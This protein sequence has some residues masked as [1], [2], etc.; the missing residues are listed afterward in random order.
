MKKFKKILANKSIIMVVN[1]FSEKEFI[2]KNGI[3][4][5]ENED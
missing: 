1:A 3:Y 5:I 2:Y 4:Y